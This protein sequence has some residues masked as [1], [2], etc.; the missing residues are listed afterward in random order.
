MAK[1]ENH[2]A[3]VEP[4]IND[5]Q[6]YTQIHSYIPLTRPTQSSSLRCVL[7]VKHH[8]A[9]QYSKNGITKPQ[10]Q[11]IIKYPPGLKDSPGVQQ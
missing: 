3:H 11:A 6:C 1:V 7:A 4:Q 5:F 10:K 8:T 9:E 2:M